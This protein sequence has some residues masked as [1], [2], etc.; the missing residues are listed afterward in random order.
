ML[1]LGNI[2]ESRH[3]FNT[4]GAEHHATIAKIL[5]GQLRQSHDRTTSLKGH[6]E[7]STSC[8]VRLERLVEEI[9]KVEKE[10]CFK[11]AASREVASTPSVVPGSLV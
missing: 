3:A 2:V 5:Q 9:S 7:F 10:V 11:R 1:E 4:K 6:D 8:S